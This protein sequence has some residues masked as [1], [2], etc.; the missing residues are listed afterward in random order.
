[1]NSTLIAQSINL[2]IFLLILCLNVYLLFIKYKEWAQMNAQRED[3]IIKRLDRLIEL[4]ET[5]LQRIEKFYP[6]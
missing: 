6:K 2:L 5:Q 1:M 3:E 4:H